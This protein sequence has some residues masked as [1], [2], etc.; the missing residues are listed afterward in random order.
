MDIRSAWRT[1]G[2]GL[3][4][5]CRADRA[6]AGADSQA[7]AVGADSQGSAAEAV[8]SG[9]GDPALGPETVKTEM[10][11]GGA[12]S[13]GTRPRRKLRAREPE[14]R[15][16]ARLHP[17]ATMLTHPGRPT[18]TR[19]SPRRRR[20]RIRR[21]MQAPST[22][23]S[24]EN[25]SSRSQESK[26]S[27]LGRVKCRDCFAGPPDAGA[28]AAVSRTGG[29]AV[30]RWSAIRICSPGARCL[31]RRCRGPRRHPQHWHGSSEDLPLPSS[32][33]TP[34]CLGTLTCPMGSAP[35]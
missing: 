22:W 32:M 34:S 35:T 3:R 2:S 26:W 24:I 16:P 20:A 30:G 27:A 28:G 25:S 23:R 1:A 15:R 5:H 13:A 7:L 29:P 18:P 9:G 33:D 17:A 4:Q 11:L 31:H 10:S 8:L 19:A 6:G 14:G 21:L 12:S